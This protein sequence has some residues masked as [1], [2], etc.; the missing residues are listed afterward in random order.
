[1][2]KHE[3]QVSRVMRS[4][5]EAAASYDKMS[6][7][8]AFGASFETKYT[9]VGVKKLDVK[10]GEK[11]LEIGFGTGECLI[12]LA[13]LVGDSGKVY[14]IDISQGMIKKTQMR[15]D[16]DKLTKR[17]ELKQ[18]DAA[19]LPFNNEMFDAIFM[20][21]TLELF[22]TFEI[23]VV[24]VECKRVL[25]KDGRLGVVAMSKKGK[26]GLMIKLYEWTHKKLPKYVDCRPI[27]VKE[28]IEEVGFNVADTIEMT[29]WGLPVEIVIAEK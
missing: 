2:K 4:K 3:N 21:F 5:E 22:D 19:R 7:W 27:F 8:Y 15:V 9:K 6:R 24:L 16:K 26:H 17:V 13:K 25:K 23:P 10:E 1:M 18:G 28:S 12:D 29:M 20:S 11:V 14:G